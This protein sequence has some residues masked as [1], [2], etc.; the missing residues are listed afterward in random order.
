MDRSASAPG[1]QQ[2]G[3]AVLGE[4]PHQRLCRR[5]VAH[6]IR[7]RQ[8]VQARRRTG[9]NG[10]LL[11]GA[12]P[13]G[14]RLIP[15]CGLDVAGQN[16]IQQDALRAGIGGP[17]FQCLTGEQL[18]PEDGCGVRGDAAFDQT[19]RGRVGHPD[20]DQPIRFGFE[21]G[22]A[23]QEILGSGSQFGSR[24]E[25]FEST[26]Q[27]GI[28]IDQPRD[29]SPGG[30]PQT[31]FAL[32]GE[33]HRVQVGGISLCRDP[34]ERIDR[35]KFLG[36]VALEQVAHQRSDGGLAHA[37]QGDERLIAIDSRCGIGSRL[38]ESRGCGSSQVLQVANR[39]VGLAG[40]AG[41][42]LEYRVHEDRIAGLALT[43]RI[44]AFEQHGGGRIQV[45]EARQLEERAGPVLGAEAIQRG[46]VGVQS[47]Q[48]LDVFLGGFGPRDLH[49]EQHGV[50]VLVR[51]LR[52]F[53]EGRRLGGRSGGESLG[54][55]GLLSHD[56]RRMHEPCGQEQNT[57][58]AEA[59]NHP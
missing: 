26:G 57:Q 42:V 10:D 44:Q 55:G 22:F 35:E 3:R 40:G 7:E 51:R 9:E 37:G 50:H 11:R 47:E 53:D 15:A 17:Q 1:P 33:S 41:E 34:A 46:I 56:A 30:V 58:A 25:A 39:E 32:G 24:S 2:R 12:G 27:I 13:T 16:G 23:P 14:N 43:R 18:G 20:G 4:S 28:L 8:G 5:E 29:G 6:L 59:G 52:L 49:R 54:S 19:G 36:L 21:D 31:G 38:D 48:P 45:R